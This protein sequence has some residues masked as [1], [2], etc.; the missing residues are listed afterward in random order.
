VSPGTRDDAQCLCDRPTIYRPWRAARNSRATQ[1][2]ERTARHTHYLN[3]SG[4]HLALK[5]DAWNM[6]RMDDNAMPRSGQAFGFLK[7]PSIVAKL[8]PYDHCN[9][10]HTAPYAMARWPWSKYKILPTQTAPLALQGIEGCSNL[11][12]QGECTEVGPL[13]AELFEGES[14]RRQPYLQ[15]R[16]GAQ[17]L[18]ALASMGK[19]L[20]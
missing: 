17:F 19:D 3:T 2:P 6:Q 18:A 14:Q 7:H 11:F 15:R 10:C 9:T 16:Q 1:A 5:C 20:I 8:V 12:E 13:S 4:D